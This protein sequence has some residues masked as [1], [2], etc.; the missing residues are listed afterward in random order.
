MAQTGKF[1]NIKDAYKNP[2]F[3]KDVDKNT[4][5]HTRNMLCFPIKDHHGQVVGVAELV[6]KIDGASMLKYV[7]DFLSNALATER[8][9]FHLYEILHSVMVLRRRTDILC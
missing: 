3:F 1:V 6:N 5:F 2:Q 7:R 8:L 9:F 4:G